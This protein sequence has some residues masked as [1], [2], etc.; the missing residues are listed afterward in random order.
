[1]NSKFTVTAASGDT[2]VAGTLGVTGISTFADEVK[3]ANDNALVTHTGST[4]MKITSSSGYVDVE[5]VR[6]TGLS[7]GKDG[8]P[9]TI[10]LADQQVT[11]TGALD[12]TSDVDIG[13]G[14]FVVTASDGSLAIA[15]DKFKVDGSNGNTVSKG[16]LIVEGDIKF[17]PGTGRTFTVAASS[18]NTAIAGTL[19]AESDFKVGADNAETFT[20]AASSGN[21][22][23]SGTLSAG[24]TTVTGTLG[25][26]SDMTVNTNKFVVTASDGSLNINSGKLTVAGA[27][28]N[29]AIAGTLGVTEAA[30]LSSTLAVTGISTFADEVKL[31]NDNALVTHTG[32][33]GMK[34]TSSSGYVDVES[35]RFT[36]LSI[37]KDGDPN[38]ILLANQQVTITG[39]L[40]VTSDVDIGSGKFVVTASDG[41]LAIATDKFNVAGASGDTL[42]AGTLGVTGATTLSSTLAVSNDMTVNTDK[43]KVTADD[44]SLAIATNKFNVA[45]AS[46]NT[47][48]AGTLGVA[49]AT[50]LSSTVDVTDDFNVNS[51]FT[52][53]AASGDT[54]V[55]GTLGVTGISTFADEVKLA[56]DNALVTHTGSTGMKITSSSGYVDVESVRFT[57]LSIGKDGDPNTILLA[58]Q[59]VTITGALDVTSDVDIGSGKFVVTASDGSLAIATDKFKVAGASGDTLIAGTLGVTGATTLSSTL[60]VVGDFDIGPVGGRTFEVTADDGSL[61]IASNKFNVAGASGNT[62]IA[63]TL[64]VTGATT[65]SST[66]AVSSDMTVNTNKFKV[67]AV[68][69]SLAIATDKFNVAG[70]SGNTLIAGTLG[71]AGATTLSSTVDVTDDFNV[72]S[73]F[74][75]TAASGDTAVAGTLGVTGIS[76]FA[77]E[78]KLANDNALVTHTGS[79][80]M[81]ITSSS[82][83]VDVESVRFTGL[84]IGKDGDPNTI[85]LADQQVTITGALDV[86]S[87]VDIGSGKFV[88]TASDGSLAIATDKFKVDGSNGNTV[89]KGT[90]IVEGDIKF[91]PGTGR[92]FTVAA[93]S[94]NTAIAGTLSAESDFKVGA[95]NAETFTV[96]A[97]SGNTA[98]SGTLSAGATTVTGTL[99]VSSD[100]TVNTNKFVVT[101]SDG[102][103]NINSGK[104]TV[105]GASGNTAIAGTLGVTEAATLSSTLAVTGIST[106]ADEVKLANDNALVTHTGSTGM[107]ITSSS[108]YVDVES[109]R[110]TGLS[111]GKD[112][113][114]NTILLANQQVTITGALDVTSDVDIGSGKFVVTASDGSLAIATD[115]FNVAG[116][117]ATH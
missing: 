16:T 101:A 11:I 66:L 18:G 1:M 37:G 114:P 25:V 31:A 53:T 6:F 14:K 33:T 72:N 80:G 2:A 17:G 36:G 84:S 20:V 92:T 76:T 97:S 71:V 49:G 96:A 106:F 78:V 22:A 13:S 32:S 42:I 108:G 75:V 117:A 34:I 47:L 19:S 81:K 110:F 91:G 4:G 105:A 48:I 46:G 100:M 68:D 54:A 7:I 86:T 113:D 35:V 85:L 57:G 39:A 74:T 102:S 52:V 63:G 29:T 116:A 93:S 70:A 58:N 60:G 45:G 99:G 10:L 90:L 44:G 95:D 98:V 24:A 40:D 8:D 62:L 23:V 83:Y 77:D 69:G 61:A 15:T 67:T 65:L 41:S 59:Q 103:L 82:G 107:K 21:T 3:L 12:V 115:K 111:I 89:S 94:G 9:N 26:S 87:D 79:T 43:F 27:S 56:N 55:A 51:K 64:G 109:V 104:L 88:V 30:T 112:G 28:G 5:S 73:K 50:T 38:T